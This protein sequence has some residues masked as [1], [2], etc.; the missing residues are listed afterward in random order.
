M[1]PVGVAMTWK[2]SRSVAIPV[3]G[4]GGIMTADD[5]L[6]YLLAGASAIQIG[7]GTFVDPSIPIRVLDGIK[8]YCAKEGIES[9]EKVKEF[10]K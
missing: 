3:I 7:T 5:A 2:V 6:Q 4:M 9:V 1:R 10:L 8:E